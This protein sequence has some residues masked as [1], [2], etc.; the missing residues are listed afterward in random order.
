MTKHEMKKL[1]VMARRECK[2]KNMKI[3]MLEYQINFGDF[4]IDLNFSIN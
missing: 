3:K 2:K 1:I 4:S